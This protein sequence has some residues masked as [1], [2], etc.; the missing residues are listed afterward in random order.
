MGLKTE[1][2]I[3]LQHTA[4]QAT[5][6]NTSSFPTPLPYTQGKPGS[7]DSSGSATPTNRRSLSDRMVGNGTVNSLHSPKEIPITEDKDGV[8][9]S[10]TWWNPQL[11]SHY[12]FSKSYNLQVTT[13]SYHF[14]PWR[15]LPIKI[16]WLA[17]SRV[18]TQSWFHPETEARAF[19]RS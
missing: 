4:R 12:T 18:L 1:R 10:P 3:R 15:M 6:H 11:M 2:S 17:P 16:V 8:S 14:Y 7:N 13:H 5:P 9:G 19:E